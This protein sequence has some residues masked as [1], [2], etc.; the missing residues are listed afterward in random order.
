[1]PEDLVA[2]CGVAPGEVEVPVHDIRLSGV[3][4][5]HQP[6][7]H[8]HR[9]IACLRVTRAAALRRLLSCFLVL[10]SVVGIVA[11]GRHPA[12]VAA[13]ARPHVVLIVADDLGIGEVSAYGAADIRTPAMDRLG[14]EGVRFTSA[15]ANA[16][17]CSPTRAALLTGQHPP[18]A[19]VPGVIRTDPANS[20]GA[21]RR[22]VTLL[23]EALRAAGYRTAAVGKWHLGLEAGD[24]PLDRGFERFRGFLGDMMDDYR[25]H[26]RH[27]IN[28]MRDGRAE[29]DPEGHATDLFTRWAVEVVDEHDPRRPLF[30]YLAYNAPHVPVQPTPEALAAVRA[31][32]PGLDETRA[33]LVAL[34]EQMDAGIGAVLTA[35]E[36]KGMLDSTLVVATSDNGGEVP[37]GATN[38]GLRGGKPGLYEGGLRIPTLVRWPG[39]AYAGRA[40]GTPVQ[41]MDLAPTIAAVAGTTLGRGIAGRDLRPLLDGQPW[42]PRDLFFSIREGPRLDGQAVY[43]MRRGAWSLVKERPR[44]S[45]HLFDLEADPLQ[46]VDRSGDPAAPLPAMLE[47]LQ[48]FMS[49]AEAVPYRRE[50][51]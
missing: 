1:M 3:R 34:V 46:K 7:W 25:S 14:R 45:Y 37:A 11:Q 31:R 20:W 35:L 18:L 17:V 38:N 47:T 36:R 30:L 22:D 26:R 10:L 39:R 24:H 32:A 42:A 9:V 33:R 16:P 28:Y 12:P 48:A 8:G 6:A 4:E 41:S 40:D 29:V 51:H 50:R 27:G 21:L 44:E 5:P 49:R 2:Q 23:P 43:A 13:A 19:G 15:Y